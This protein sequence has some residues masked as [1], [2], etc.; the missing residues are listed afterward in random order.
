MLSPYPLSVSGLRQTV[1]SDQTLSQTLI[2]KS[3]GQMRPISYQRPEP[4]CTGWLFRPGLRQAQ[5]SKNK[6]KLGQSFHGIYQKTVR[7]VGTFCFIKIWQQVP[8]NRFRSVPGPTVLAACVESRSEASHGFTGTALISHTS[9]DTDL[10][11]V[12]S[13]PNNIYACG[14]YDLESGSLRIPKHIETCPWVVSKPWYKH[15]R[16]ILPS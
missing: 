5:W 12:L 9:I 2:L 15:L 7:P 8:Q 14:Q 10:S 13:C 4:H 6:I 11:I 1:D 3:P 16:I